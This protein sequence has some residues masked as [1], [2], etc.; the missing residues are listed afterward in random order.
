[1]VREHWH[2]SSKLHLMAIL[3]LTAACGIAPDPKSG[4]LGDPGQLESAGS[5]RTDRLT[6]TVHAG[7]ESRVSVQVEPNSTC[8]L[9]GAG[10]DA[11]FV[12]GDARGVA[13]FS[14][15]FGVVGDSADFSL[16]C[17]AA[18]SGRRTVHPVTLRAVPDVEETSAPT[19]WLQDLPYPGRSIAPLAEDPDQV[20]PKRLAELH[21]PPRPD[22]VKSPQA[23]AR[24]LQWVSKPA[25]LVDAPPPARLDAQFAPPAR[26]NGIFTNINETWSG[27]VTTAYPGAS[28]PF[29]LA[30]AEWQLPNLSSPT[31]GTFYM[32]TWAGLGGLLNASDGAL[33]Q[34][35]T[36]GQAI[37]FG[38]PLLG[39]VCASSYWGWYEYAPDPEVPM[40]TLARGDWIAAEVFMADSD[41][42]Q[43]PYST[44]ALFILER[45]AANGTN[46]IWEN[47]LSLPIGF[48]FYGDSAEWIVERPQ[49]AS[50][51]SPYPFARFPD[52]TIYD[53][54]G[55]IA[56]GSSND[57]FGL[58][59]SPMDSTA[60]SML[61]M[62]APPFNTLASVSIPPVS[63][64]FTVHWQNWH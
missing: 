61:E 37:C 14:V 27:Y 20:T 28:G 17:T 49:N 29:D 41:G 40:A 38:V 55:E 10:G 23:Y 56:Q 59:D 60:L 33:P 52:M 22:R 2:R 3:L 35:G 25:I 7:S 31:G 13:T 39:S 15:T 11:L 4:R 51:N 47:L 43:D 58:A 64:S 30:L 5:E 53:C 36:E 34:T 54:I 45:W 1:M 26:V 50:N 6:Q 42:V 19:A 46:Q 24:W 21:I 57:I 12:Y 9:R 48:N 62:N 8:A 18:R 32:S 44:T 63:N 16:E